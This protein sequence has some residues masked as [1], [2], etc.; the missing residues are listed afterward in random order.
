M[1]AI[2]IQH[3][4]EN[5]IDNSSKIWLSF[6]TGHELEQWYWAVYR[7][8]KL[9]LMVFIYLL[10]PYFSPFFSHSEKLRANI[11]QKKRR[12]FENILKVFARIY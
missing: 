2:E 1:N 5:L 11:M 7:G 9:H 8:S 10:F 3:P 4:S 6:A 12:W